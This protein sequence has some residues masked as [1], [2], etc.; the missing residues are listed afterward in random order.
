MHASSG[1]RSTSGHCALSGGGAQWT[2]SS[3]VL[4]TDTGAWAQ[5]S[6]YG[7]YAPFGLQIAWRDVGLL[8]YPV[9]LGAYMT[10][11]LGRESPP[12]WGGA[13]RAG[14][15]V[16]WRPSGRVPLVLGVAYDHRPEIV[17]A[18]ENR[19]FGTVGL[20]LPLFLIH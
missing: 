16:F 19:F 9:D 4:L 11:D 12:V 3:G 17:G 2:R 10:A 1:S 13:L 18:P 7:L 20:E 6:L 15:A 8:V 5:G 14:A